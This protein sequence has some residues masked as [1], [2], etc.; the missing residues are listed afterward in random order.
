MTETEKR[1]IAVIGAGV[2][3]I[4]AAYLLQRRHAVTI[5][6]K[7][8]QLG[9][10]TRTVVLEDGPDAGLGV[11][12]GF[13]VFNDRTYPDFMKFLDQLGIERQKSSMSFS[14]FDRQTGFQYSSRSPFADR[15]NLLNPRFWR[16]LLEILRFNK[17]TRELV[18][19]PEL[20]SLTL[21]E[22]LK[23]Q[24]FGNDL[25][26][27]YILPMGAAIWSTPDA[28]MLEFPAASFARFFAN[29]GLLSLED[30]PQWY[31]VKGGSHAYVR[32]F[33]KQFTGTVH[34]GRPIDS[35]VRENGQVRIYHD[36]GEDVFDAAVIA[37]HADEALALLADPTP[38]EQKL[39]GPWRYSENQ[40]V[41]HT[42]PDFL[43]P[44]NRARASW[45]Y[46][47][48]RPAETAAPLS[49]TYDM[50]RLQNL[51]ARRGYQVT[52]NPGRPVSPAHEIKVQTFSHPMYTFDAVQTQDQLQHL[53]GRQNTWFCGS[54]FRSGFHEDAVQS[55]VKVGRQFGIDL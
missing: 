16:F 44:A 52:L 33:E 5:F 4:V 8:P 6:E 32:A 43:P 35:V 30:H 2:A 53:N 7:G 47:R 11:D 19:T 36:Q 13:I 24:A 12:T 39:L 18:D 54:Y 31:T 40:V 49:M 50:N 10:H 55:A 48:E 9:G 15:K 14:Y 38:E 23:S 37:T 42:D 26:N 28:Q 17:K 46:I 45:N 27:A 29:H 41:L 34:T 20:K 25:M 1:S 22:Y 3:G 21:G 51:A